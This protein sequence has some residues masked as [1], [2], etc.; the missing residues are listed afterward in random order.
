MN[1]T[2]YHKRNAK[3][4]GVSIAAS[5]AKGKKIA[6]TLENKKV[7]HIGAKGYEDYKTYEKKQGGGV[8]LEK[9]DAYR[10]RHRCHDADRFSNRHLAC[11]ILWRNPK[12]TILRGK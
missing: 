2:D 1:I 11:E 12:K 6:V 10:A 5:T 3:Q 7:R 9:L 4:L 8:A